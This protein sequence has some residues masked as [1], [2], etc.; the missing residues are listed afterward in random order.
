MEKDRFHALAGP[1]GKLTDFLYRLNLR[2]PTNF[3]LKKM[4]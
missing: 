4:S 3:V 1:D 2:R